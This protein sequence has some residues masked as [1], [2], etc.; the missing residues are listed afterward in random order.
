MAEDSV[1]Y[2]TSGALDGSAG[3]ALF[4]RLLMA[5]KDLKQASG[6]PSQWIGILKG[7]SSK[8]IKLTEVEDSEILEHLH[9]LQSIDEKQKVSKDAVVEEI[10][11]RLPRIK[12]VDLGESSF[13]SYRNINAGTYTE[14]LYIL[15]SEAMAAD[16]RIED[17]FFRIEELGFD[18]SRLLRDPGLVDRLEKE[19]D[20][21]K[22]IRPKMYDFANHHFS[23]VSQKHGKNVMA[24]ARTTQ[25]NGLFFIDE[26]QS[27]WAQKGRAT[28]WGPGFPKAPFVSNTEQWAGLV[29][30]DL[31]HEAAF[32]N[33]HTV[34]WINWNM[35]NGW[36]ENG[37]QQGAVQDDTFYRNII[38]KIV[39]KAIGK[40][41][42][43]ITPHTV[44]TKHGNKEVL[45]FD[46]TPSV[47]QA[48][49]AAQP[50]YSREALLPY[51]A[52]LQDPK[53]TAERD[54]VLMDCQQMLG[55]VHSVRFCTRVF[56]IATGSQVAGRYFNRGISISLRAKDMRRA[57]RHEAWHFAHENF[58]MPHEQ[59]Q[60]NVSFSEGAP[61]NAH[62]RRALL[63]SGEFAAASQC[64]N[65]QE[66]A[67]HAF[68]LWSAGKLDL[69]NTAEDGL[70][71]RVSAALDNLNAWLEHKIF[72]V[73]VATPEDLFL[74]MQTGALAARERLSR[75]SPTEDQAAGSEVPSC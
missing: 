18:P 10:L 55:N 49:L 4:S 40:A 30:R 67:A 14:R 7:L 24:H 47:R 28:N 31:M 17:L 3:E 12:R 16:D 37:A 20:M 9:Q 11:R 56:D 19:L 61:L 69:R 13:S 63:Q 26:I 66:C 44:P 72:G 64:S 71:A 27:D 48:L 70:F 39:E 68:A 38:P 50:L 59:R 62:T 75:S 51:G 22:S 43:C 21:L 57:A 52:W 8:G 2:I 36:N 5:V 33:C 15:A 35:R 42:G 73:K 34:A 60:M 45:G 29:V 6:P 74:A 46:M 1:K 23:N 32:S 65:A 58:L 53:R 41:G 25:I 54:L